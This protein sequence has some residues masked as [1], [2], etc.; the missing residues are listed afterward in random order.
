MDTDGD[1]DGATTLQ[2]Y[3]A[4]TD[5]TQAGSV[6][7]IISIV[8]LGLTNASLSFAAVSNRTYAVE[9]KNALTDPAWVGGDEPLLPRAHA[10]SAAGVTSS[11]APH[12]RMAR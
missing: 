5:P 8:S 3:L 4:G 10:V 12:G 7:R 9:F 11:V 1:G 2:E 6:L